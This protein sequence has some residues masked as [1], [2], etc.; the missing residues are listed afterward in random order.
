MT[1][2]NQKLPV[3]GPAPMR[4]AR[5]DESTRLADTQAGAGLHP[6]VPDLRTGRTHTNATKCVAPSCYD[7]VS[8]ANCVSYRWTRKSARLA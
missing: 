1:D 6:R 7:R 4:A 5:S 3:A 2:V 8:D